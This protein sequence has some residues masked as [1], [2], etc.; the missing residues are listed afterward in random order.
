[1]P[2]FEDILRERDP[3]L[4]ELAR[5]ARALIYD[6]YPQTVEVVWE[7]QGNTGFGVGPKKLTEHFAW[8][9]PYTGHVNLGL[10]QGADLPD[11]EG[12][13]LRS[14]V[15]LQRPA[16]RVLLEKAVKLRQR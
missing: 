15:D 10:N 11:P 14:L 8:V 7:K 3:A 1:M 6:V 4:A 9:M 12:V 5:K 16:L 2:D 13:K